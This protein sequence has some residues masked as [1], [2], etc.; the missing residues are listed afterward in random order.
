MWDDIFVYGR[1]D[2]GSHDE[3]L[4]YLLK[5]LEGLTV[6]KKKSQ[7]RLPEIKF[8]G[9]IFSKEVVRVSDDK[10][11]SLRN[12][13]SPKNASEAA[14]FLN[15]AAFCSSHDRK[16]HQNL[17]KKGVPFKWIITRGSGL[18]EEKYHL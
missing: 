5:R 11:E 13:N 8:L 7:L 6:S 4:R 16:T 3:N 17:T 10:M 2:D 1:L 15:L 12:A 14:G 9:L 18:P